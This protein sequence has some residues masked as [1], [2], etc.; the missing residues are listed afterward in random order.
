[1]TLILIYLPFVTQQRRF[2][3]ALFVPVAI[4]A[5]RGMDAVPFLRRLDIRF[6]LLVTSIL[7]NVVLLLVTFVARMV[8]A[9]TF[10]YTE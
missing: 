10:L 2:S 9:F 4:L 3:V 8:R 5:V 1:M 6:A 7:T